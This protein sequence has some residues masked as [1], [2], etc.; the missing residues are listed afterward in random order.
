M[1]P[2]AYG[3]LGCYSGGHRLSARLLRLIEATSNISGSH[4]NDEVQNVSHGPQAWAPIATL[5]TETHYML[6]AERNGQALGFNGGDADF[7]LLSK[8]AAL[9]LSSF[10]TGLAVFLCV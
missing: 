7:N 1:S 10:G 4:A 8:L 9:A 6:F 2:T 3:V 5:Y